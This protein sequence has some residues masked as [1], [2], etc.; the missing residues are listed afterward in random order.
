MDGNIRQPFVVFRN[1]FSS[2]QPSWYFGNREKDAMDT[3]CKNQHGTTLSSVK[4]LRNLPAHVSPGIV[5]KTESSVVS[6]LQEEMR[7]R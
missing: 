4:N 7:T 3:T 1:V 2:L 6:I 5:R